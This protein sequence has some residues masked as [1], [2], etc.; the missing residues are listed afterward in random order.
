V[1]EPAL[2]DLLLERI[3]AERL[4]G[5]R[6]AHGRLRWDGLDKETAGPSTGRA[7]RR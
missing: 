3:A 4:R 2:D 5:G 1:D 7:G 6:L